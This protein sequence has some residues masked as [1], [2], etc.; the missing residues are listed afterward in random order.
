[1]GDNDKFLNIDDQFF[2][3]RP[4]NLMQVPWEIFQVEIYELP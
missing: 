3:R 2:L 1:M 4:K